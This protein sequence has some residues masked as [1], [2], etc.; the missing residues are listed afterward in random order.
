MLLSG[1]DRSKATA[2]DRQFVKTITRLTNPTCL[3]IA[4]TV[5]SKKQSAIP[6]EFYND[7]GQYFSSVEA[8]DD[9]LENQNYSKPYDV[10]YF[11]EGGISQCPEFLYTPD[12]K[13]YVRNHLKEG[14]IIYSGGAAASVLGASVL[15]MPT[16]QPSVV[17]RDGLNL[18]GGVSVITSYKDDEKARAHYTN[19][20]KSFNHLIVG[21]PEASGIILY[22]DYQ[23]RALGEEAVHVFSK[24]D[25][26]EIVRLRRHRGGS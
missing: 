10:I 7:Y 14:N 1:G 23:V 20:A 6:A 22:S 11:S 9:L 2:V 16:P 24:E 12:F 4:L 15:A 13:I 3:Y 25:Q 26:W 17:E 21:I 8:G 5:T 19:L 18:L